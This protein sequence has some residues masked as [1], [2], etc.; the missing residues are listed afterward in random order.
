M[1]QYDLKPLLKHIPCSSL[2]YT[3]WI[4]VGMALQHE[5]YPVS[6]WDEWSKEDPARY[7][8][9]VCQQKWKTFGDKGNDVT[10]GTI[11]E[12][13]RRFGWQPSDDIKTFD[14]DDE[15]F[16]D[17]DDPAVVI[18][19]KAWVESEKV[20]EAQGEEKQE[21]ITYLETLFRA[22]ECVGFVM[23][24]RKD[25]DGKYKPSSG[26]RHSFTAGQIIQRL[27]QDGSIEDN[28][29]KYDHNGGAWIRFNPLDGNGVR[30]DN[31]T[32]FRYALVESDGMSIDEQY[33]LY[34]ELNLPIAALVSS[35]G[36]S[37]HA[38]VHID[39]FDKKEYRKRVDYLY[40]VCEKNGIVID[41]QNKN[42]SR[43]SRMP[44]VLR[45]G[46]KRQKLVATNIGAADYL[47][48]VDWLN[49]KSDDL[50]QTENLGEILKNP[51][52]L[53]PVLIEGILRQGHKML[54]AGPSKAGK[55]YWLMELAICI[56]EG[57]KYLNFQC[58]EGKVLY[59]NMELDR[60]SC[61]HRFAEIYK[62]LGIEK[63]K[64]GNIDVWNLRGK[65][66]PMDG[67]APRLIHRAVKK[68][69]I[70]VILDPLYKVM[71]GDENNA[72][73]MAK[74]CN[75]FDRICTELS[76]AMIYCH[77]H[78]K[79]AQGHKTA[80]DRASGSGVFARDPDALID[81]IEIN[82][83]DVGYTLPEGATSAWRMSFT[84]REFPPVKPIETVF[85]Y[86]VHELAEGLE[87]AGEKYG[88]DAETKRERS[89][90]TRSNQKYERIDGLI[91][92][93]DN[94][95]F[96]RKDGDHKIPK[97]SDALAYFDGQKGFSE[98]NIK[99]WAAD[100]D[101]G[102]SIENGGYLFIKNDEND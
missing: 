60:A 61:Y 87:G 98:T 62:C 9:G 25:D 47:T 45:Y 1:Q 38:I 81:M 50:P 21:L 94:W 30:N 70:A 92:F 102:F 41:K 23:Q 49:D 58:A 2:D 15:I 69:Y 37:L 20:D 17:G 99:R 67:L 53:T 32:S 43:L 59:L 84:L 97:I 11:Y 33:G 27:K 31:V 46:N 80:M 65:V 56:S 88:A 18:K 34:K 82:P 19:D 40:D 64:A 54:V 14:W 3:E 95:E 76:C 22:D 86:P 73:D 36:K 28:L 100:S 74:F 55:S 93:I 8:P 77:H 29:E 91:N 71:T 35:A 72:S 12:F 16:Y 101:A 26:G 83:K 24:S 5:G 52:E 7:K 13:A 6:V 85:R 75:Q 39:A 51:P 63:P 89:A 44:G 10:G 4:A 78:S 42:P 96:I 66:V 90:Q 57:R 79:G 48:W 68:G